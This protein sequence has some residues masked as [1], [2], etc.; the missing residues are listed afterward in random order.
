MI[1]H[2]KPRARHLNDVLRSKRGGY[3]EEK[4]GKNVKRAKAKKAFERE[5]MKELKEFKF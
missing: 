1:I 3:H 4:E 5:L 2:L